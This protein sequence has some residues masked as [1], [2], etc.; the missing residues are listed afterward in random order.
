MSAASSRG[1]WL[2]LLGEP[3]GTGDVALRLHHR[4]TLAGARRRALDTLGGTGAPGR[5]YLDHGG[6]LILIDV[7]NWASPRIEV[8]P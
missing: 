2:I 8:A 5:I 4:G 6:Q 3:N 1:N 7:I